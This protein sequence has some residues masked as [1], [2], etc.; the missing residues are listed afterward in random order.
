MT[1]PGTNTTPN[2]DSSVYNTSYL[3]YKKQI[4]D[5]H[6]TIQTEKL[7]KTKEAEN[8]Q[9]K[10]EL[11]AFE[12]LTGIR[13]KMIDKIIPKPNFINI[14][15]NS[16]PLKSSKFLENLITALV[17]DATESKESNNKFSSSA[18]SK[19]TVIDSARNLHAISISSEMIRAKTI[20]NSR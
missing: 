20:G 4:E 3:D 16:S 13:E 6:N 1:E 17:D 10:V 5:F 19:K 11:S 15:S 12:S 7:D 18:A 9:E 2:S 14:D 8:I